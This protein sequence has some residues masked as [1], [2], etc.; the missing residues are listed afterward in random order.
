M[1]ILNQLHFLRPWWFLALLPM[2]LLLYLGWQKQHQNGA[3]N[4]IIAA[5]FQ[6]L[7]LANS[8]QQGPSLNQKM[9]L[10]LLAFVWILMIFALSGPW[11][12]AIEIPAK[13]SHQ[14]NVIVLDLSLSMMADDIPPERL[15][16]IKYL[17][18]DLLKQHPEYATGMV[19]YAGSAHTISPISEDNATLLNLLPSLDPLLMPGYGS[20]PLS[21]LQLAAKLLKGNQVTQGHIIWITDDLENDQIQPISEW[22]AKH[23]YS[24]SLMTVG[25]QAGGVVQIPNYG[26][27]KDNSG[28]LVHPTLPL[29]NFRQLV[30][31]ANQRGVTFNWT[32]FNAAKQ[33]TGSLLPPFDKGATHNEKEPGK[34]VQH[35]LDVGIFLLFLIIPAVALFYR[36]GILFSLFFISPLLT[37]QPQPSYAQANETVW[38]DL[39]KSPDQLGYQAWQNNQYSA[40]EAQFT[41]PQWRASALYKLG[42]YKEAAQLFATDKSAQGFYNLGNALAMDNQLEEAIKAYKQAL[43]LKPD[44]QQ[45]KDNLAV[46]EQLNQ[47]RNKAEQNQNRSKQHPQESAKTES[48]EK[49]EQAS[50][51]TETKDTKH[52]GQQ[53]K[54][55]AQNRDK[56]SADPKSKANPSAEDK[57]GASQQA[58]ESKQKDADINKQ[59]QGSSQQNNADSDKKPR[60]TDKTAKESQKYPSDNK[61]AQFDSDEPLTEQQQAQRNWL[62]QIPDQPGLFLKRKFEYQYQQNQNHQTTTDKPW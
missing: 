61:A 50:P 40:A 2:L 15:Q 30:Q 11:L 14:G 62:Q 38:S 29:D 31:V 32:Q 49:T 4:Q 45:A 46:V 56:Q 3:W 20:D 7:L 42:K 12:K 44:W 37:L 27:L 36:R 55:N 8:A 51:T 24:I 25:T 18:T 1:E 23:D 35:P 41:D 26:L 10:A 59:D 13:K 21:A 33:Q 53:Q 22:L 16:R 52:E 28:Q 34:S 57:A 19:A 54:Q 58:Q 5:K 43:Q 17:L 60:L 9:I 47:Q 39:F 48:S 6:K